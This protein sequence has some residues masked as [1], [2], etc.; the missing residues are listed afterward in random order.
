MPMICQSTNHPI[1]KD[2]RGLVPIRQ[3][4]PQ[5]GHLFFEALLTQIL[6]LQGM[7]QLINRLQQMQLRLSH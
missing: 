3:K 1:T 2:A 5:F 4:L 6:D 7:V